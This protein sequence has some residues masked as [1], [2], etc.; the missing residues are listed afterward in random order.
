MKKILDIEFEY[1]N[2][3]IKYILLENNKKSKDIYGFLNKGI[4]ALLSRWGD[5]DEITNEFIKSE[6]EIE[7]M[8][9]E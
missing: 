6:E 8:K 3:E 4:N 9:R 1:I 2:E 5:P 7:K